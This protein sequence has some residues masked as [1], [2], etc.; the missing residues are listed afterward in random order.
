MSKEKR[1]QCD[2][3]MKNERSCL[4]AVAG[5]GEKTRKKLCT[6]EAKDL[7]CEL[8]GSKNGCQLVCTEMER[9]EAETRAE[10]EA[11]R[12]KGKEE[13]IQH[14][15]AM[16]QDIEKCVKAGQYED[17]ALLYEQLNEPDRARDIRRM[18]PKSYL[19]AADVHLEEQGIS[20][21]CPNC[22]SMERVENK[23]NEAKCSHCSK[24]YFIP[25]KI[26][27]LM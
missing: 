26:L 11:E 10:A 3:L 4:K 1:V 13:E 15:A 25:K 9:V 22:G 17:A 27:D 2:Y 14:V 16:R 6:N 8:C 23:T 19:V 18:A 5:E 24:K 20:V 12:Q 7:C 21:K